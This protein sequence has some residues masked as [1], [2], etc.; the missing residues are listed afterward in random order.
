MSIT[1]KRS[2]VLFLP[3]TRGF[4]SR[5]LT[6]AAGAALQD[7]CAKLG[8]DGI[9]PDAG[10]FTEGLIHSDADVRKYFEHWR[11]H[12]ADIKA[13]IVYSGDFMRERAVLDTVRLLPEDVPVFLIVHNDDPGEMSM[14]K[15]NVGDSLCGSLSVHHNLR[16]LG[17]RVLRSARIDMSNTEVL[18]DVLSEYVRIID[19]IEVCRGMRIG[20]L[21]V[22][23]VSFV[24]T[25]A[26]QPELF[27][28]G[29]S[30]HT[31]E[32]LE[33]W[34]NAFLPGCADAGDLP[35]RL[36]LTSR[37]DPEDTRIAE[38]RLALVN[39]M[40]DVQL[41]EE[42]LAVTC[43]CFLWVKDRFERD[44]IDAGAIHCWPEFEQ[45]FGVRPCLFAML[46]NTLLCKPLVCEVDACHA[47]MARLAWT[48]TAEAG[49]ILDF[50]NNGW[51]PR[52]FNV[53]HCSQTPP[54]W[55]RDSGT[56]KA[57]GEIEGR[58]VPTPFTG[59][60]AATSTEACHAIV[61]TGH[62]LNEDPGLRGSSGWAFVPNFPDVL[63]SVETSGIHHFVAMKG[64]VA[65]ELAEVL[66]FRGLRVEDLSFEVGQL[67]VIEAEL[68]ALKRDGTSRPACFSRSKHD[69]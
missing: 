44:G 35:G 25:F 50:N 68:P 41:S 66:R 28:L 33:L 52:I 5:A 43:R 16:L 42:E 10:A 67:E 11:A 22:N 21:G 2:K 15:G 18:E 55:L 58:I 51:D 20:L 48:L 53:F 14:K 19:G 64:N 63:S 34:G 59:V 56:A 24:T 37:V 69:E 23:P 57:S 17:R 65:S 1:A 31:Y 54:N 47:I 46:C 39:M 60:A 45:F 6:Q 29:F 7:V 12:L 61:F 26:N 9:F 13:L 32:L 30:L 3:V 4:Y 49:V 36:R 27:R 38:A 8:A 40:G 62:F